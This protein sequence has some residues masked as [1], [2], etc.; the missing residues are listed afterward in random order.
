MTAK[1]DAQSEDTISIAANGD[2]Q[3]VRKA[4]SPDLKP[5]KPIIEGGLNIWST[6]EGDIQVAFDQDMIKICSKDNFLKINGMRLGELSDIR[7]DLLRGLALS[8][9]PITTIGRDSES[10]TTI[11]DLL[12]DKK[13]DDAKA[14]STY[15]TETRFTKTGM[16]RK[17]TSDFG[18]IGSII[19]QLADN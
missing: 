16:E 10:A 1:L 14:E 3:I 15:F 2:S 17:T 7:S 19:A 11:A 12:S 4:L 8:T 5:P 6:E 18:L 13:S 9:A